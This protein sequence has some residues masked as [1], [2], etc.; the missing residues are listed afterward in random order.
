MYMQPIDLIKKKTKRNTENLLYIIRK[1]K[2]CCADKLC[3]SLF[4][5][6]DPLLCNFDVGNTACKWCNYFFYHVQLTNNN[7]H[8]AIS[9]DPSAGH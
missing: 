7:T 9:I 4:S 3:K 5:I 6:S 1:I 8:S 2:T